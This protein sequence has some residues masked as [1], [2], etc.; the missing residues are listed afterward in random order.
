MGRWEEEKRIFFLKGG[1]GKKEREKITNRASIQVLS[2]EM[3][4]LYHTLVLRAVL[5]LWAPRWRLHDATRKMKASQYIG[6]CRTMLMAFIFPWFAWVLKVS[7]SVMYEQCSTD[8]NE[9]TLQHNSVGSCV[10]S[11]ILTQD[12]SKPKIHIIVN[13]AAYANK[14]YKDV[15]FIC[16]NDNRPMLL[17]CMLWCKNR[18]V[19]A[20]SFMT[21]YEGMVLFTQITQV[22]LKITV[23]DMQ[24]T[25]SCHLAFLFFMVL[26]MNLLETWW[27]FFVS[28]H[29]NKYLHFFCPV[30]HSDCLEFNTFLSS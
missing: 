11:T 27:A 22:S 8:N 1:E 6:C 2:S 14:N 16:Q 30:T 4:A 18:Q 25:L 15:C 5:D 21:G 7:H 10:T 20:S 17:C 19:S 23:L 9:H 3:W 24:Q 28:V 29:T 26:T 12:C 13:G